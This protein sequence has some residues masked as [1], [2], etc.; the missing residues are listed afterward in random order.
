KLE[1]NTLS[2]PDAKNI[3]FIDWKN[4]PDSIKNDKST[5]GQDQE[6]S[7]I[8]HPRTTHGHVGDET[9]SITQEAINTATRDQGQLPTPD[10]DDTDQIAV[11]NK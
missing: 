6:D 7:D 4:S 11:N 8:D 1:S 9:A 2:A 3:H 10:E 5:V